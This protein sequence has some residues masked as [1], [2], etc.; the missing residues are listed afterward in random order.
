[1][2][3]WTSVIKE[4]NNNNKKRINATAKKPQNSTVKQTNKHVRSRIKE[5]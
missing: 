3:S 2:I 4:E 5:A 1:M